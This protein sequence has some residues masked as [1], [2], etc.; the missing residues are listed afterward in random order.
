MSPM[1]TDAARYA[2]T[3]IEDA[4]PIIEEAAAPVI[5]RIKTDF[6]HW[7]HLAD[8]RVIESVGLMTHWFDS[9]DSKDKGVPVIGTYPNPAYIPAKPVDPNA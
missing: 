4:A 8:G 5:A 7:I 3:A 6:S 9:V 1:N 2:V